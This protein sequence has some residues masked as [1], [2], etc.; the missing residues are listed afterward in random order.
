ME[1][2]VVVFEHRHGCDVSAYGSRELALAE[3]ARIAREWWSEA[4]ERDRSLPELPPAADHEAMDLYFAAQ[5][6]TEHFEIAACPLEGEL[7]TASKVTAFAVSRVADSL[8]RLR[9]ALARL[10]PRCPRAGV[11]AAL[12]LDGVGAIEELFNA[13]Y[14]RE[15][16]NL[17]ELVERAGLG[18]KCRAEA[19]GFPCLYMN[20]GAGTCG[21]CGAGEAEG[22]EEADG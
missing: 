14:D 17:D 20:V 9:R 11:P 21:G 8:A 19:G 12:R 6:G 4:R 3:G 5:Q 10:W 1:V 18:W 13:A 2:H 16:A 22:K 7:A 15:L